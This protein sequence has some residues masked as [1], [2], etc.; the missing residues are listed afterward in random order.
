MMAS[1]CCGYCSSMYEDPRLLPCLH[2]FCFKCIQSITAK[3]DI[4]CPICSTCLIRNEVVQPPVNIKLKKTVEKEKF[5]AKVTG[6][7]PTQCDSCCNSKAVAY[8]PDCEDFLCSSCLEAHQVLKMS[9]SH[10]FFS[11]LDATQMSRETLIDKLPSSKVKLCQYHEQKL[12]LYCEQCDVPICDQC[13]LVIHKGHS[14]GDSEMKEK[15]EMKDSILKMQSCLKISE[16]S[17]NNIKEMMQSF[18]SGIKTEK[19][20]LTQGFETLQAAIDDRERELLTEFDKIATTIREDLACTLTSRQK[21]YKDIETSVAIGLELQSKLTDGDDIVSY[22]QL[23]IN[24]TIELSQQLHVNSMPLERD[25]IVVTDF[26]VAVVAST[27]SDLGNVTSS[28]FTSLSQAHSSNFKSERDVHVHTHVPILSTITQCSTRST[29]FKRPPT[30]PLVTNTIT[31]TKP[32]GTTNVPVITRYQGPPTRPSVA[33]TITSTK[34]FG[35]TNVPV[36]TRFQGPPTRPSV[37]NTITSTKPFGTTNVPVITRFQGPLTR[38]SVTNTIT[39]TKPFGT[40]NVPVITRFQGPLTRPSVTN[41]ITSTKPF[42]TTNKPIIATNVP[43]I[44]RFQGQN[45]STTEFPLCQYQTTKGSFDVFTKIHGINHPRSFA[46][47]KAGDV[48]VTSQ[49]DFVTV[50]H[51]KPDESWLISRGLYRNEIIGSHGTGQLEFLSPNGIA[52]DDNLVYVAEN[53]GNRIHVFTTEGVFVRV[54][55]EKDSG[56]F[57]NPRDIKIG[58]DDKIYIADTKNHRVQV[59]NKNNWSLSHRIVDNDDCYVSPSSPYS[60][61]FDQFGHVHILWDRLHCGHSISVH[62]ASGNL[63][64]SY[65]D[66][67]GVRAVSG[68][69]IDSKNRS[70]VINGDTSVMIYDQDGSE[71]DSVARFNCPQGIEI[72]ADG[73]VW[74]ADTNNRRLATLTSRLADHV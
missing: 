44:T 31:S 38:P 72:A 43:V 62:D 50:Y 5:L 35:T 3:V 37:A 64:R 19:A 21:L 41:T 29:S 42:G 33:N 66:V 60:I 74:V 23:I 51:Q 52:I 73:K 57:C 71:R 15:R 30:R 46:F 40:T 18:E 6:L 28:S 65:G 69:V 63:L 14:V 22:C 1:L 68:I 24:R 49:N 45:I 8:C 34:P 36:I 13:T 59:F 11:F 12:N 4:K 16:K 17:L 54:V 7:T 39:S 20:K 61:S 26:N 27:V 67:C 25:N 58:P 32:F 10:S 53:E 55:G 48:F 9:R 2:S 56:L 47:S 70:F